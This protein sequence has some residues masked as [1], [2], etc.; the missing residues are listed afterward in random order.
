MTRAKLQGRTRS[1]NG[2][3]NK[4]EGTPRVAPPARAVTAS[5][6]SLKPHQSPVSTQPPQRQNAKS[7]CQEARRVTPAADGNARQDERLTPRM[8]A[9]WKELIEQTGWS[10]WPKSAMP[11]RPDTAIPASARRIAR[12]APGQTVRRHPAPINAALSV[13]ARVDTPMTAGRRHDRAKAAPALMPRMP[14]QRADC[15]V[16]AC[17][18]DPQ[19]ERASD[20][21]RRD[22]PGY[23]KDSTTRVLEVPPWT[24]DSQTIFGAI[25]WDPRRA[26]LSRRHQA[27]APPL[28]RHSGRWW[29]GGRSFA[30]C[31]PG[32]RDLTPRTPDKLSFDGRDDTVH[33]S[34]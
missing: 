31:A 12:R 29:V 30:Q 23:T 11:V 19:P 5:C 9:Q 18:I 8:D 27:P 6:E 4:R 25:C 7:G 34:R 20:D 10:G 2:E 21:E 28:H 24:R 1:G 26:R 14:D 33:Q 15:A 16:T 22:G 17:M 13:T 32:P 3:T